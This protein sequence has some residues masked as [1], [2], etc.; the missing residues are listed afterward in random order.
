[1]T[2]M[3]MTVWSSSKLKEM[4]DQLTNH[5]EPD[6]LAH[7]KEISDHVGGFNG[8]DKRQIVSPPSHL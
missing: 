3:S 2:L 7:G 4:I 6:E 1:M 5:L 8:K